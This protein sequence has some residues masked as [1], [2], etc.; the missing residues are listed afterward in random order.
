MELTQTGYVCHHGAGEGCHDNTVLLRLPPRQLSRRPWCS[1]PLFHTICSAGPPPG[2]EAG[3]GGV[4]KFQLECESVS[5]ML[6]KPARRGFGCLAASGLETDRLGWLTDKMAATESFGLAAL[7][8][9]AVPWS[10]AADVC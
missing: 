1:M 6:L 5:R 7:L 9:T 8:L 10:M 4:V 3:G 2:K